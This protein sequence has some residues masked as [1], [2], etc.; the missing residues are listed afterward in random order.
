M[1]PGQVRWLP[2]ARVRRRQRHQAPHPNRVGLVPSVPP[3]FRKLKVKSAYLDGEL[4]A[5]NADHHL[6]SL[7]VL[8]GVL[9]V[10]FCAPSAGLEGL[11][12][13]LLFP[14][15]SRHRMLRPR[16]GYRL[17]DQTGSAIDGRRRRSRGRLDC[18]PRTTAF[19][20][21]ARAQMPYRFDAGRTDRAVTRLLTAVGRDQNQLP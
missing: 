14:G 20:V 19:P 2:H 9:F 7:Y 3:A 16:A 11:P 18:P 13:Q 5:L 21:G 15:H 10:W 8:N 6:R 17:S 1:P 12:S 4:C